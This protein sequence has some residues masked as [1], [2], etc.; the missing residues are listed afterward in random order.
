[1]ADDDDVVERARDKAVALMDDLRWD[2]NGLIPRLLWDLSDEITRLRTALASAKAEEREACA[3]VAENAHANAERI[4]REATV[5]QSVGARVDA[6]WRM[7]DALSIAV[8]IRSRK[9]TP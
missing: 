5:L 8:A 3:K 1:M 2:P 9:D 6:D 4:R 7:K